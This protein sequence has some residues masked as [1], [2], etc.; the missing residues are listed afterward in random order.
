LLFNRL[1]VQVSQVSL[2]H[3]FPLGHLQES[4]PVATGPGRARAGQGELRA[5]PAAL[6][7]GAADGHA[8]EEDCPLP[9][10]TGAHQQVP[11]LG[12]CLHAFGVDGE[13]GR[14]SGTFLSS[15]ACLVA[16]SVAED[17]SC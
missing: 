17:A 4:L 11:D 2:A 5:A 3:C 14:Q 1:L 7:Q 13:P 9:R 10:L 6:L 15:H 12:R 8:A 16:C